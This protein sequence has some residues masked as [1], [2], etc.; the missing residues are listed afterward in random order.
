MAEFILQKLRQTVA[1][2]SGPLENPW[3]EGFELGI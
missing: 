1:I 2:I 3:E